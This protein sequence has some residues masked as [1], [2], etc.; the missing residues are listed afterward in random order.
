MATVVSDDFEWDDEKA[1]KNLE[2]HGVSF[3]E[4]ATAVIDPH[5]LFFK[6]DAESN[7]ER[8]QVIGRS[9]LENVLFV[10]L[11]E[12]GKRDRIIS[13]RRATRKEERLYASGP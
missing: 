2:K 5:A 7:E 12:R 9:W 13:A 4:A 10:V 1:A 3:E 11:V 6:D 8:F